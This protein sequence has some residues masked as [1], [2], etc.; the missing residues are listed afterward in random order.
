MLG[1]EG[2]PFEGLTVNGQKVVGKVYD[3][4]FQTSPY[5]Y[6]DI[7]SNIES[8]VKTAIDARK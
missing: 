8:W 4:P 1:C 2:N 7:A 5:V 6:D 3:P